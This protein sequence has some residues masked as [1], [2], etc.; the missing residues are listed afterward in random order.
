[1]LFGQLQL[2]VEDIGL[3]FS[4]AFARLVMLKIKA[5]FADQCAGMLDEQSLQPY[6]IIIAG[7]MGKPR[8]DTDGAVNVRMAAE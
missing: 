7:L 4:F 1:M 6:Q 2:A 3:V 5:D 8:V